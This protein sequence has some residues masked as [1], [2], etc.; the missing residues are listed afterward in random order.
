MFTVDVDLFLQPFTKDME[1][2]AFYPCLKGR[3]FTFCRGIKLGS[4]EI[5]KGIRREIAKESTR[6]VDVLQDAESV[7][8][9]VDSKIL[10]NTLIPDIRELFGVDRSLNKVPLNFIA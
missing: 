4:V 2:S 6:P 10:F 1:L 3:D 9:D 5:S 8:R 7:I